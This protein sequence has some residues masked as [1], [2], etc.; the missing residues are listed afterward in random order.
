[1]T[2]AEAAAFVAGMFAGWAVTS[3]VVVAW[4]IVVIRRWRAF[5]RR[6]IDRRP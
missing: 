5:D 2:P 1:M 6:P 3:I 4:L